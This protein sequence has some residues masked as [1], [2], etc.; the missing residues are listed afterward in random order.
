MESTELLEK[1]IAVIGAG[2][3]GHAIAQLFAAKANAVSLFDSN[4]QVLESAPAR[5]RSNFEIL[6]DLGFVTRDQV[7][8]A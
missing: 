3:M 2:L 6:L 7:E 5:I 1:K 4:Q 8:S